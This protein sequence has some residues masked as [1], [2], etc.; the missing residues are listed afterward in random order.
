MPFVVLTGLAF[1]KLPEPF[2]PAPSLPFAA[3]RGR[4]GCYRVRRDRVGR[5]RGRGAPGE[6]P[7]RRGWQGVSV[8]RYLL[9]PATG[10]NRRAAAWGVVALLVV[11]AAALAVAP[12]FM[13]AGYDW[14]RHT[15]SESAAQG[16]AGAWVA[17]LGFV[18]FGLAVLW[19][20][21]GAA[22]TWGRG[23]VWMHAAFGVCMVGTA[24]FSHMPWWE[25]A[26]FDPVEDLLHSVTATVM[27]FAFVFGVMLR[28]AQ[29]WF[30][31]ASAGGA[32]ARGGRRVVLDVVAVVAASVIPLIMMF[33]A[34]VAGLV[35]RLMFA[36]AYVWYAA[37][38]LEA[39]G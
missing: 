2:Y 6:V 38:A 20:A 34:D 19:L 18:A 8:W 5:H 39:G 25:G 37:A 31:G 4:D 10:W 3:S 12:A 11:S 35:Q 24:A 17:R 14:V 21:A 30:G 32:P 23:A 33:E 13:P 16:L 22:P 15:T 26:A 36:V 9:T 28:L 27:G 1:V 7:R 29:R